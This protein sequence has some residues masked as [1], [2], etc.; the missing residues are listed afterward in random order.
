MTSDLDIYRSARLL[1]DQPG[2]DAYFHAAMR[3]DELLENGDLDGSTVWRRIKKAVDELLRSDR[4]EDEA[5]H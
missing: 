2:E 3:A 4:T 5:V 1:I